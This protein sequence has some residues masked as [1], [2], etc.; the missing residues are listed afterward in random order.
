MSALTSHY[1]VDEKLEAQKN[2]VA[3]SVSKNEE[4]TKR[5][6]EKAIIHPKSVFEVAD[7]ICIKARVPFELIKEIGQ[8]ESGWQ[9]IGNKTGGS[10]FGD[11]QVIDI[12]FD[13]WYKR[14][15]LHGGKTRRN[16]LKIGI[17]YIKWLY[18][19]EGSW[20][21][22]RFAYGRGKW[23]A[24]GTWTAMEKRFMHKIDWEKYDH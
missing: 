4:P 13:Y 22:A 21:R 9:F 24:E 20:K 18:D 15:K 12:T 16:Y 8:N 5:N 1:M 6:H 19:R 10:D 2:V 14:L 7:S 17:Y 3:C 11:L 23:R